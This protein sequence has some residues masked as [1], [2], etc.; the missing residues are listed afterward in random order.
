MYLH[1]SFLPQKVDAQVWFHTILII[2]VQQLQM[3][4]NP[5]QPICVKTAHDS[6]D[7]SVT[8]ALHTGQELL[9]GLPQNCPQAFPAL[10]ALGKSQS[11]LA[12]GA[13]KAT[14]KGEDVESVASFITGCSQLLLHSAD[15]AMF[16][17]PD[18]YVTGRKV[19]TW[20]LPGGWLLTINMWFGVFTTSCCGMSLIPFVTLTLL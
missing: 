15:T 19:A 2:L 4:T 5:G 20:L 11:P 17:V 14:Q 18:V 9:K 1:R 3:D 6:E 13:V 16:S 10:N 12:M 7:L 8:M